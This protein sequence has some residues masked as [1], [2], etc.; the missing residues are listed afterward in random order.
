M[1]PWYGTGD[2]ALTGGG[3]SDTLISFG[4]SGTIDKMTGD[5]ASTKY[6]YNHS[7]VDTFIVGGD[8]STVIDGFQLGEEI[9]VMDLQLTAAD[10]TS[11]YDFSTD[12]T[13]FDISYEDPN[14]PGQTVDL[15][16]YLMVSGNYSVK[17]VEQATLNVSQ[18]TRG[19]GVFNAVADNK[20]IWQN[21]LMCHLRR[22]QVV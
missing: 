20:I 17:E 6:N 8:G 21:L 22:L 10:F 13:T 3:G 5:S 7:D 15:N 9:Y 1:I 2:D 11:S 18:D 19:S 4:H 16:S 12:Q 14:N